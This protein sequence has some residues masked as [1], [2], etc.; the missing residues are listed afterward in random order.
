MTAL[1]TANTNAARNGAEVLHSGHSEI[2]RA[3]PDLSA[4]DKLNN[5]AGRLTETSTG[6]S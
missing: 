1:S 2:K 4:G 5:A 6:R 3:P